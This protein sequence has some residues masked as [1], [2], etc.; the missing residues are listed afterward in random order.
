METQ[1][2][3]AQQGEVTASSGVSPPMVENAKRVAY[4]TENYQNIVAAKEQFEVK[5]PGQNVFAIVLSAIHGMNGHI[6]VFNEE[7]FETVF[8][9]INSPIKSEIKER[10]EEYRDSPLIIVETPTGVMRTTLAN[11]QLRAL[12]GDAATYI[13]LTPQLAKDVKLT[14]KQQLER[15]CDPKSA[16]S[17]PSSMAKLQRRFA[18]NKITLRERNEWAKDWSCHLALANGIRVIEVSPEEQELYANTDLHSVDVKSWRQSYPLI[19]VNIEN[20]LVGVMHQTQLPVLPLN[21][22]VYPNHTDMDHL[23][24]TDNIE[25]A[26]DNMIIGPNQPNETS[27]TKS[28][29]R[30]A[31]NAVLHLANYP[32]LYGRFSNLINKVTVKRRNDRGEMKKQQL[33]PQIIKLRTPIEKDQHPEIEDMS[34]SGT[35][36]RPHW[37]RGHWRAAAVG[38]GRTQRKNIWIRPMLIHRQAATGGVPVTVFEQNNNTVQSE[39]PKS[40]KQM[41]T[42]VVK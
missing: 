16:A 12:F 10:W 29:G 6:A 2:T 32:D 27:I 34:A 8:N 14:I 42:I 28:L 9:K 19:L 41:P 5:Y 31:L 39:N 30:I 13:S 21:V 20:V 22:V 24:I 1:K 25:D 26:I 33:V 38:H 17:G 23:F 15:F 3:S 40:G 36:R 18:T 11:A 7:N 37:R 4:L 35:H